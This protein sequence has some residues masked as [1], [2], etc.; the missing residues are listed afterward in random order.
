M[1]NQNLAMN[2]FLDGAGYGTQLCPIGFWKVREAVGLE[3]PAPRPLFRGANDLT[4]PHS[5]T[6]TTRSVCRHGK[7]KGERERASAVAALISSNDLPK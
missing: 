4:V 2:S 5:W 6:Q 3:V 7:V 1:C